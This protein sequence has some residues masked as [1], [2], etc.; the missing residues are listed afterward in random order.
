MN[1]KKI[2]SE[3]MKIAKILAEE[4]YDVVGKRNGKMG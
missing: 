4:K 3:L 2:A 1:N